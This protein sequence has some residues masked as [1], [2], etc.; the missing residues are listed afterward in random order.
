MC[1]PILHVVYLLFILP[2]DNSE[3]GG[4]AAILVMHRRM[5][6]RKRRK[7]KVHKS[8]KKRE[9]NGGHNKLFFFFFNF[10]MKLTLQLQT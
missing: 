8:I 6:G 5:T 1:P 3:L 9:R 2:V 4:E 10:L 7:D